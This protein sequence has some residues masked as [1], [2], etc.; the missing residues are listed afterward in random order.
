MFFG[1][2]WR[3]QLSCARGRKMDPKKESLTVYIFPVEPTRS[4]SSLGKASVPTRVRFRT[5]ILH[6]SQQ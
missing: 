3:L 2:N 1:P 5:I 6:N 4:I